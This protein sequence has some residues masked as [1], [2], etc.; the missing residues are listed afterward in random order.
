MTYVVANQTTN[1]FALRD[2]AQSKG[3]DDVREQEYQN[4]QTPAVGWH[5]V[6]NPNTDENDDC[7]K[8]AVWDLE[9]GCTNYPYD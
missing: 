5:F 6:V 9:E 4:H 2:K 7:D 1:T 8:D 3:S